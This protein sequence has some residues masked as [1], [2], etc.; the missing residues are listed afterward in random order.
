MELLP[1]VECLDAKIKGEKKKKKHTKSLPLWI[2][3][4]H[5]RAMRAGLDNMDLSHGHIRKTAVIREL[6]RLNRDIVALQET[7]IAGSGSLK[8]QNY[9]FSP[10]KA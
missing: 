7:R 1:K 10:G 2:G 8:E 9:T 6:S 5:V 4:W 3:T